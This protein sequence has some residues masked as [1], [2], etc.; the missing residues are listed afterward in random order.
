M[1]KVST[2]SIT[3][4]SRM[5]KFQY[6]SSRMFSESKLSL[7]L[8][9]VTADEYIS[10]I[11]INSSINGME[12]SKQSQLNVCNTTKINRKSQNRPLRN[13]LCGIMLII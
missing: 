10:R 11:I 13:K 3:S 5:L 4:Y 9:A 12:A 7:A 6:K 1:L 2:A 8:C